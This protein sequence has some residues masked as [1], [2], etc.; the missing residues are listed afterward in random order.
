MV[1]VLGNILNSNDSLSKL[2]TFSPINSM[3]EWT[4]K[5][6]KMLNVIVLLH[7]G[8]DYKCMSKVTVLVCNT[9]L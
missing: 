4:D 8:I 7:S 3:L 1:P 5:L 6:Q 9:K 2:Q